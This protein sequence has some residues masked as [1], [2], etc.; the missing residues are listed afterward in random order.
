M[1][2]ANIRERLV[3]GQMWSPRN[4]PSGNE[5]AK[6]PGQPPVWATER[7]RPLALEP[8]GLSS[9]L[10]SGFQIKVSDNLSSA[11][12]PRDSFHAKNS[13]QGTLREFF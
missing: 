9:Q 1:S 8:G 5:K 3:P 13:M 11:L 12:F 2:N 4:G 7:E 10:E 6:K